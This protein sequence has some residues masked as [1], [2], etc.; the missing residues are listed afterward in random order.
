MSMNV[1]KLR[2]HFWPS[3]MAIILATL[4]WLGIPERPVIY[5]DAIAG[6]KI[7]EG[8][9]ANARG[10]S[11]RDVRDVIFSAGCS[12]NGRIRLDRPAG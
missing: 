3:M 7:V 2:H 4:G 12:R 1:E 9:F 8:I 6:V 11:R 5:A 10:I